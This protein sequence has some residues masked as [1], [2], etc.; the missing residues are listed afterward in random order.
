MAI[1]LK[2]CKPDNFESHRSVKLSFT[3]IRCLR[4]NFVEYECFLKSN[5]PNILALYET[6]LDDSTDSGNFSVR[7]DLPLIR[8]DSIT[9]MHDLAVYV[10]EGLP[11]SQ[12]LSLENC[13]FLLMFSTGFTSFGVLVLFPLS[14]TFFV[15][16]YDF[17]FYFIQNR[18]GSLNQP[19]CLSWEILTSIIRNR[20]TYS[21]ETDRPGKLCYDFSI[22]NNIN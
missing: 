14:I 8:K 16:M 7:D 11:F 10:K 12:D 15:F 13:R 21:G 22:S 9:H 20:L 4:S 19:I 2:G 6:N 5:S 3:K 18:W 17:W 1:L